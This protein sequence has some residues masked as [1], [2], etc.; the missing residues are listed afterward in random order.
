MY[1]SVACYRGVPVGD[2]V[3]ESRLQPPD[4]RVHGRQ[5]RLLAGLLHGLAQLFRQLLLFIEVRMSE[6]LSTS[7]SLRGI[8][9]RSTILFF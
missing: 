2:G 7:G 4:L 6:I 5:L 3:L 1:S 8:S 9:L